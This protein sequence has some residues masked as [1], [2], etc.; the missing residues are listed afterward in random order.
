MKRDHR[1]P[2]TL[3]VKNGY[4]SFANISSAEVASVGHTDLLCG[5]YMDPNLTYPVLS[6]PRHVPT[7]PQFVEYDKQC[8][9]YYASFIETVAIYP[10]EMNRRRVVKIVYFLE[11]DTIAVME[12]KERIVRRGRHKKQSR[13]DVNY[14]WK[15]LNIG[16]EIKLNGIRFHIFDCDRFTKEF[17]SSKGIDFEVDLEEQLRSCALVRPIRESQ[18]GSEDK[19]GKTDKLRRFLDL[20]GQVLR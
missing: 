2:Q 14:Q 15:D 19:F 7:L 8:L 16:T 13:P 18:L 3:K 12:G 4:R 9:T 5:N 10:E 17:M 1:V 20:H 11:D 6:R